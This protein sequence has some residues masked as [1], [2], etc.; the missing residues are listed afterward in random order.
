[1]IHC[2][3]LTRRCLDSPKEPKATVMLERLL[4]R[5]RGFFVKKTLPRS[6]LKTFIKIVPEALFFC[7]PQN[8]AKPTLSMER[9]RSPVERDAPK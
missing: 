4:S 2:L 1:M 8:E 9:L 5:E 7:F 3:L 6:P